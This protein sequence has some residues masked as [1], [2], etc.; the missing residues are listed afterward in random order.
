MSEDFRF[1]KSQAV[2]LGMDFGASKSK[3]I[4]YCRECG[5]TESP[6]HHLTAFDKAMKRDIAL[7]HGREEA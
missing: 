1:R 3:T 5:N 2:I 6:C 4:F 7:R